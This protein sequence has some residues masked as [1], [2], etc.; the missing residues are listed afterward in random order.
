MREFLLLELLNYYSL[1]FMAIYLYC[2][3]NFKFKKCLHCRPLVASY[4]LRCLATNTF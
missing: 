1:P 2:L 3:D 4:I